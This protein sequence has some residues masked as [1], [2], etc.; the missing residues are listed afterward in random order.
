M[1]WRLGLVAVHACLAVA[2]CSHQGG[3]VGI[4][5]A[6]RLRSSRVLSCRGG[7]TDVAGREQHEFKA[8]INQLM[9]LIINAFYSDKEIFLRELISN[10]ADA[11]DKIRHEGLTDAAALASEPELHISLI[12]DSEAGTLTIQDTGVGMSKDELQ[13]NLGTIAHS[14]TKAFMQALEKGDADL[15]LIGQFGVGF[16]SAFLVADSVDVY[17]KHN[18]GPITHKWRSSASGS[19]TIEPSSFEGLRRGTA[20]VLHLK[21]DHRHLLEPQKLREIVKKHSE[22]VPHP[23]RLWQR[24]P[25]P[26]LPPP[27]PPS[28]TAEGEGAAADAEAA[29]AED[30]TSADG[31]PGTDD[32]A[33]SASAAPV[34][35]WAT[36]NEQ[37]PIWM[38]PPAEVSDEMYDAFYR[39]ISADWEAP[40]AHS[41]FTVEGQVEMRGLLFLPRRAPLD[42][43][44]R[45]HGEARAGAK[46]RLYVRRVLVL[47]EATEEL[48]PDWL[49]FLRGVI[50]SDDLPLNVSREMLQ[51]SAGLLRRIRKHIVKKAVE[52]MTT[53]AEDDAQYAPWY[54]QFSKNIKLGV[55]EEGQ[56]RAKLATLLRYDSTRTAPG[57]QVGLGAYVARM[58]PEQKAIYYLTGESLP[59]LRDSP[60]LEALEARGYE[61][62]LMSEPID[63]Y[64]MQRLNE[65]E[66]KP[67]VSVANADLDLGPPTDADAANATAAAPY[68]DADV[69]VL[70]ATI[71]RVLGRRV[72]RVKTSKR[73]AASPCVLVT[74]EHG[75]SA[76]MER[77]M[78][79][80][81]LRDPA[82]ASFYASAKTLEVN[83]THPLVRALARK[84]AAAAAAAAAATTTASTAT[85]VDAIGSGDADADASKEPQKQKQKQ[86]ATV[87]P[88]LAQQVELLYEAA[89]LC[90]GFSLDQPK[91]FATRI[92]DL[93]GAAL[94]VEPAAAAAAPLA[95]PSPAGD[96]TPLGGESEGGASAASSA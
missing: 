26:P 81:A 46:L 90:S 8:E 6:S 66:G 89:L 44:E 22:F 92:H 77:I 28:S 21:P 1:R 34:M 45:E 72:V 56:H 41:H 62:L 30:A 53:L 27:P 87:D 37:P 67:F 51:Q 80:Q 65:F 49:S 3:S 69:D 36:L 33:A 2:N 47:A 7:A 61:V 42:L 43:F 35:E 16:Y 59:L 18:D 63:E 70:C 40:R 38:M 78:R 83:P 93:M 68:A 4:G 12:P 79:A 64:A 39:T 13:K 25:P 88:G 75:W 11:I 19:Y 58:K 84:C 23:I 17:S 74:D 24:A 50:D 15:S 94:G 31:Q 9:S 54:A 14:G 73:L 86:V 95:A 60:F 48:C 52:M 96:A 5:S 91:A 55:H 57:E 20:V 85:P 10:A 76:N 71:E 29:A 82:I 32:A